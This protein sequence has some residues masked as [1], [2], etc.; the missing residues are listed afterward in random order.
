MPDNSAVALSASA[1]EQL[2]M[3]FDRV[4]RL[5]H[6]IRSLQK[7]KK[8]NSAYAEIY[9][10]K[11]VDVIPKLTAGV[12]GAGL[13]G[14]YQLTDDDEYVVTDITLEV[15]NIWDEAVPSNTKIWIGRDHYSYRYMVLGQQC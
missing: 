1:V 2:R 3:L 11:S 5:E 10:G 15:W 9:F 12:A 14:I 8:L 7:A 6:E 13:C 4:Q